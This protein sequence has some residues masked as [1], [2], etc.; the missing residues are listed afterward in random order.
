MDSEKQPTSRGPFAI[1]IGWLIGSM[2]AS[3]FIGYLTMPDM[4]PHLRG[5][6]WYWLRLFWFGFIGTISSALILA[7][8]QR[9]RISSMQLIEFTLTFAIVSVF[10]AEY[11]S[12]VSE[13]I[14]LEN[15][16]QEFVDD[17]SR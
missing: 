11:N 9:F 17:L 15:A 6:A 10:Y 7:C 13:V 14:E 2:L 3:V 12:A 4:S 8:F 5:D 16:Y 1:R